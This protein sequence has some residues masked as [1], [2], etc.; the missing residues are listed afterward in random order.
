M[1]TYKGVAIDPTPI[2]G[3]GRG[4]LRVFVYVDGIRTTA[5]LPG[6]HQLPYKPSNRQLKQ[7]AE[8]LIRTGIFE[9]EKDA[10][11]V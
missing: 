10:V 8:S 6:E 1:L 9:D 2:N 5:R 7:A 11:H 3:P 4:E